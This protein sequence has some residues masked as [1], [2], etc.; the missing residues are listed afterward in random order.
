MNACESTTP[1]HPYAAA[2]DLGARCHYACVPEER[3]TPAVRSFGCFVPDLEAMARWLVSCGIT[4]VA[5]EATGVYWVPVVE[6]LWRF[7]LEPVLVDPR[8]LKYV[9]GR[10]SDVLD[11]QWMQHLHAHGLLT[12]GYLPPEHVAAWRSYT[13]QRQSLIEQGSDQIRR[14]HKALEQ[15][16][17]QIHKV[18]TDLTGVTGT[19]VVKAVLAGE[20]DPE[21]LAALRRPGCKRPEADFVKALA[22]TWRAEHVFALRQAHA[23]YEFLQ[24]QL[25][26]VDAQIEALLK[27]FAPAAAPAPLPERPRRRVRK[28][29]P[30]FD[31]RAQLHRVV[32]VDLTR[33]DGL[34]A[35]TVQ[36]VLAECG[37]DLSAFQSVKHFCSWLGLCPGTRITGGRR[38]SGRSRPVAHRAATALR[39]AAQSLWR[40]DSALGAFFRRQKARLGPAAAI[41]ATAHKL[42]RLL[43]FML[44]RGQT[45]ADPGADAY[46]QRHREAARQ[47]LKR[48]AR[49]L[50]Y[51]L[52]D[53]DT[54]ELIA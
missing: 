46:E 6:V 17:V 2:V 5:L 3:A 27:N 47:S 40:S 33:I 37:T 42:A 20:R 14:M 51:Q 41:T 25:G 8:R 44:T 49:T 7:G 4:T 26:Q 18:V 21:V 39:R 16:G 1:V 29:E 30:R 15:M 53:L 31:L 10:K 13:R 11:C 32:G 24:A 48:R 22:G 28:N 45:Y 35:L 23:H 54:G 12:G 19:A 43:Y 9:P 38:K 34:D 50:G 36:T 52:L